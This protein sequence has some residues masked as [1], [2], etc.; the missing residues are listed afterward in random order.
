MGL[1]QILLIG[2]FHSLMLF[3]RNYWVTWASY[4]W[5]GEFRLGKPNVKLYS[6]AKEIVNFFVSLLLFIFI[7]FC[8]INSIKINHSYLLSFMRLFNYKII[9]FDDF[10]RIGA[11]S[12]EVQF[13]DGSCRKN[14]F[15]FY[16][17]VLDVVRHASMCQYHCMIFR[18]EAWQNLCLWN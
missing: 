12:H 4:S 6:I 7:R 1:L 17:Q 3:C 16:G 15:I 14:E 9:L 8:I 18:L 2:K 13:P 11:P 5:F 10:H